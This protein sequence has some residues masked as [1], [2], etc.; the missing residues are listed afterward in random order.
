MVKP[1]HLQK[2][3]VRF[4]VLSYFLRA[5][6]PDSPEFVRPRL[7]MAHNSQMGVLLYRMLR[8]TPTLAPQF[9]SGSL[10]S[11]LPISPMIA[12]PILF[13]LCRE[14]AMLAMVSQFTAVYYF[15]AEF[16]RVYPEFIV[17]VSGLICKFSITDAT[18]RL[19]VRSRLLERRHSS[20]MA[21]MFLN[22]TRRVW[23]SKIPPQPP[24]SVLGR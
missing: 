2:L 6:T 10:S 13:L 11:L 16:L 19:L 4:A 7:H 22:A 8:T 1:L 12:S 20:R 17:G 24:F 14:E 3:Q 5:Y 15:L 23:F 9:L 21:R 18:A